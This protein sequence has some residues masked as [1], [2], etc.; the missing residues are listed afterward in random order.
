MCMYCND[1]KLQNL[2]KFLFGLTQS[3]QIT[4]F[5]FRNNDTVLEVTYSA[6]KSLNL[7]LTVHLGLPE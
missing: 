5:T 3:K 7:R 4:T 6:K 1:T 2:L